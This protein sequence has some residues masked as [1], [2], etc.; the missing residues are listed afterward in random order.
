MAKI[1]P[2]YQLSTPA[3]LVFQSRKYASVRFAL[4]SLTSLQDSL[5]SN[6]STH[7]SLGK[8]LPN[9]PQPLSEFLVGNSSV[10]FP[11]FWQTQPSKLTAA[12][13]CFFTAKGRG[14]RRLLSRL[15]AVPINSL[16]LA[17]IDWA[18]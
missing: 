16:R 10:A 2:I 15:F 9:V 18:F 5:A 11:I 4:L 7:Q 17:G 1:P 3:G 6:Y 8:L 14:R 13:A 12:Q